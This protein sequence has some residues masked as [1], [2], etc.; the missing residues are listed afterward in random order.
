M[1][2]PTQHGEPQ[3]EQ[4]SFK[5]ILPG[6]HTGVTG[7]GV[8]GAGVTGGVTGAAPVETALEALDTASIP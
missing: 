1:A 5:H 4:A 6:V 2:P 8:T 7:A 3:A